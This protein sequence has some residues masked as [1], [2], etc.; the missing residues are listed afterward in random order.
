MHKGLRKKVVLACSVYIL[1]IFLA[2]FL[3]SIV[4][5]AEELL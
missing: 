2:A 4:L 3:P 5:A 1:V